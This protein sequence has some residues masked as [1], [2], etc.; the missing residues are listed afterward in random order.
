MVI[1]VWPD[2]E[3]CYVEDLWEMSHKSDDYKRIDID[4]ITEYELDEQEEAACL[5]AIGE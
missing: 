3:W 5:E 1:C 2:G 4:R